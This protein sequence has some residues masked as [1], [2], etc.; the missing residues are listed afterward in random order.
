M[1][2]FNETVGPRMDDTVKSRTVPAKPKRLVRAI[3]EVPGAP[4]VVVIEAGL[5]EMAKSAKVKVALAE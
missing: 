2:G 1:V 4:K 5:A 3:V